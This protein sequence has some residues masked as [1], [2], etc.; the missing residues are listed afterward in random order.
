MLLIITVSFTMRSFL[1]GEGASHSLCPY[2][3]SM[4]S[5]LCD[6]FLII[7]VLFLCGFNHYHIVHYFFY[8]LGKK[9][10]NS[11]NFR[12]IQFNKSKQKRNCVTSFILRNNW[13]IK[14]IF[15]SCINYTNPTVSRCGCECIMRNMSTI[16]CVQIFS[17]FVLKA[18]S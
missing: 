15:A 6:F 3:M 14:A 4:L 2:A 7:H 1:A 12:V 13:L 18:I 10:G 11:F 5:L 8:E 17:R 9:K 16:L